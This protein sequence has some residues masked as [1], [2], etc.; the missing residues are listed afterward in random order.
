MTDAGKRNAG[1]ETPSPKATGRMKEDRLSRTDWL[2]A[3][4][5]VLTHA[6]PGG[7]KIA[8]VCTAI[9]ASKGSF[10]WHFQGRQDFLRG[11][12]EHWRERE[13]SALI[14]RAEAACS[15][16]R[17]RIWFVVEF[18]TLGGYDVGTEVAMRQWG[19]SDPSVQSALEQVDAERL[20]FFS[21]HFRACGFS[22]EDAR[23]RAITVY[24][25]TLSCGYMLT[26]EQDDALER[27]MRR[28]LDLLL[29]P[30][31]VTR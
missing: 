22:E 9:G 5:R 25:L 18:V 2:E 23:H 6:G 28:S 17:D 26:G 12:F 16:P 31:D 1:D 24:S 29:L 14:K 27:R 7:L 19:Q 3:G 21:R 8:D 13:T 11:L 4:S 30:V 20:D 15:S 10:Y